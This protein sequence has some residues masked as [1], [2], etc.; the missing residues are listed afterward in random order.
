MTTPSA[1][2]PLLDATVLSEWVDY[3]G[4]MNDACYC[5]VFSRAVD[6]LI[7][8]IG[9]DAAA[10]A[11]TG[12]TVYTLENLLRY[13]LEVRQGEPL[14]VTGQLLE[15]DAKRL[16]LWFEM[17]HGDTGE[18]L[19]TSEQLLICI[20]QSG[21]SPRAAPFPPGVA[22][23]VQALQAAHGSLPWPERAGRGIALKR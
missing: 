3:N 5:I 6:N 16:R 10:R 13:L 18:L 14:T 20:D 2:L 22:E 12:H 7:D 4:H 11:T 1:P 19:A 8:Y 21:A 9:L 17:R 15:S 23:R